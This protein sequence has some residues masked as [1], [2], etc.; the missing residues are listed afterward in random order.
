MDI[1]AENV[2]AGN[3]DAWDINAEN[4]KYLA[5]CFA[6][7]NITCKSIKG[8]FENSK[9]FVLD[10]KMEIGGENDGSN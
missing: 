6:Y 9:H 8:K 1:K 7:K 3:I 5:V 4:I 10:G 2:Y